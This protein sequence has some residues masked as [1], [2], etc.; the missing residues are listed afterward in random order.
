MLM[1]V[2]MLNLR[3]YC[4]CH[5]VLP[6]L[7]RFES[8]ISPGTDDPFGIPIVY[9]AVL[10]VSTSHLNKR[11]STVSRICDPRRMF[12]S[13]D[14]CGRVRDFNLAEGWYGSAGRKVAG[15][16]EVRVMLAIGQASVLRGTR[17]WNDE[18][19]E[20]E[21]RALRG[22]RKRTLARPVAN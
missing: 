18:A 9:E 8:A 17:K 10:S 15:P 4:G 21:R 14:A 13:G 19:K 1:C 7:Y 5:T 16:S 6:R 3:T 11:S 12:L 20:K 22:S 2:P